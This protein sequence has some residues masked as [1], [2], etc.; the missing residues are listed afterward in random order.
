MTPVTPPSVVD[1]VPEGDVPT[2]GD[3]GGGDVGVP[4]AAPEPALVGP[5][6]LAAP[7]AVAALDPVGG[8]APLPPPLEE[9]AA[10]TGAAADGLGADGLGAAV[11]DE[12]LRAWLGTE[13]AA[14]RDRT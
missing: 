13:P 7:G 2:G 11:V 10:A 12:P 9:G 8:V 5:A 1:R 6:P 3:L 4:V 14:A